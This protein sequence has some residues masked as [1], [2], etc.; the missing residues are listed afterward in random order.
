MNRTSSAISARCWAGCRLGIRPL[1][2]PQK[3]GCKILSS[4]G[5]GKK[6]I[7]KKYSFLMCSMKSHRLWELAILPNCVVWV[8]EMLSY[9]VLKERSPLVWWVSMWG[10]GSTV[11]P[12]LNVTLHVMPQMSF[13]Q[14][15]TSP[16]GTQQWLPLSQAWFLLPR[17]PLSLKL[18][19][20]LQMSST[21]QKLA[22]LPYSLPLC[23][24]G[25]FYKQTCMDGRAHVDWA[26]RTASGSSTQPPKDGQSKPTF[27]I[28]KQ[29]GCLPGQAQDLWSKGYHWGC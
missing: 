15:S 9:W 12:S 13:Q 3:E 25:H 20:S 19:N 22:F 14:Q 6:C 8:L 29:T 26:L 21:I 18:L 11:S 5:S 27:R 16:S 4:I 10:H 24:E 17:L 7:S 23:T 2:A 1:G 28:S